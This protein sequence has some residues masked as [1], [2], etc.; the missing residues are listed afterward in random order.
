M[1]KFL[2]YNK[3][4][5]E[6]I[7]F[8][9]IQESA[10]MV[11]FL[12]FPGELVDFGM[13]IL[14]G[15]S[16]TG[17]DIA[18]QVSFLRKALEQNIAVMLVNGQQEHKKAL[19]KI[20]GFYND[21]SSPA[22]FIAPVRD[23]RNRL[24]YQSN[25]LLD[26]IGMA[27]DEVQRVEISRN[28]DGTVTMDDLVTIQ[29]PDDFPEPELLEADLVEYTAAVSDA[30]VRLNSDLGLR[31]PLADIPEEAIVY[32]HIYG[33]N[34]TFRVRGNPGSSG[35]VPPEGTHKFIGSA[36]IGAFFDNVTFNDQPV[37]WISIEIDGNKS[38]NLEK[39]NTA[40]RGWHIGGFEVKGPEPT[41]LIL[42][43]SSPNN[44]TGKEDYT[45]SSQFSVG[46][47]A[48]KDG[49]EADANYTVS[50]STTRSINDWEVAQ[51]NPNSW[52]F[53]QQNPFNA[54]AGFSDA[55]RDLLEKEGVKD[56]FPIISNSSLS[57]DTQTV[58]VAEPPVQGPRTFSYTFRKWQSFFWVFNPGGSSQGTYWLTVPEGNHVTTQN[59]VIPLQ[60]AMPENFPG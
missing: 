26:P 49:V 11:E 40:Q 4:P 21:T 22:W 17:E 5:V 45:S 29:F 25:E 10:E 1:L 34:L 51:L 33:I 23:S 58:W 12:N 30:L 57:V 43:Q 39:N 52:R 14:D 56:A 37:Q 31:S 8:Q 6:G 42:N 41:G 27:G 13:I 48:G 60:E 3:A 38:A 36:I 19:S 54:T 50:N 32:R 28:P 44:V 20:V 15:G 16:I 7:V 59:F 9:K 46:L 2:V 53:F 24:F 55:A 47:K 35:R 18:E